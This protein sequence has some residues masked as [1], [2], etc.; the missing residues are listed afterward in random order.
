MRKDISKNTLKTLVT[1]T[2]AIAFLLAFFTLWCVLQA[3]YIPSGSMI[4]TFQLGD[5]AFA[6]KLNAAENLQREDI[7][8]FD[9]NTEANEGLVSRSSNPYVK[10][11][12]GLPGDIIKVSGGVL[13]VNG[14]PQIRDYTAEEA[15]YGD[16][17]PITVPENSF[18]MMGD[19]RN[20]SADSRVI[21]AIPAENI[22]GKVFWHSRNPILSFLEKHNSL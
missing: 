20:Y 21:G 13:Y 19:N 15:I 3:S 2:T 16:F 9:P 12:I 7:V 8:F 10:R 17:G 14:E 18:F 11:V 4:P 22:I 5:I 6:S 1:V